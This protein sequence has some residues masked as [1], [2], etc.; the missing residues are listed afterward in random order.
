MKRALFLFASIGLFFATRSFA[1]YLDR[2]LLA[3]TETAAVWSASAEAGPNAVGGF[4][5]FI[6]LF[7]EEKIVVKIT[8]RA[9]KAAGAAREAAQS[10]QDERRK[11]RVVIIDPNGRIVRTAGRNFSA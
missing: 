1:S 9:S 3:R 7:L 5:I 10:E 2:E 4:P 6:S 8:A 11:Y